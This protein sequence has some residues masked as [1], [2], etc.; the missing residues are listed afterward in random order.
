MKRESKRNEFVAW[1]PVTAN[2]VVDAQGLTTRVRGTV[3]IV[4]GRGC[5]LPS[6]RIIPGRLAYSTVKLFV[7]QLTHAPW[8][9]LEKSNRG[10][11]H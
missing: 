11:V 3:T 10:R 5:C 9:G 7:V 8:N 2:P 1:L 6:R 4:G